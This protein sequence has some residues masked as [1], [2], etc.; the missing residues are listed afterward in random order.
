MG[1]EFDGVRYEKLRDMR[2]TRRARYVGLFEAGMNFTRTAHAGGG[3]S[4]LANSSGRC[5]TSL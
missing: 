3:G 2:E 1:Y 5:N 4:V